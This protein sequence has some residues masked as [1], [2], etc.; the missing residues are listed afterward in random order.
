M[1]NSTNTLKKNLD[2]EQTETYQ[3]S[4][5]NQTQKIKYFGGVPHVLIE[6]RYRGYGDSEHFVRYWH[7]ISSK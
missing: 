4:Q 3:A 7:P 2:G 6:S 1:K 5:E